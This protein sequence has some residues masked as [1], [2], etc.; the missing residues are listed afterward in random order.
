MPRQRNAGHFS[1][2]NR[3]R[4]CCHYAEG[5]RE[6]HALTSRTRPGQIVLAAEFLHASGMVHRNVKPENVLVNVNGYVRLANFGAAKQLGRGGRAYTLCGTPDYMAPEVVTYKGYGL[7]VDHW[8]LGVVL[9]EMV[10]GRQPFGAADV[11]AVFENAVRGRYRAPASFSP[12]LRS[13]I[14]GLVQVSAMTGKGSCKIQSR[15][16]VPTVVFHLDL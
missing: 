4:H 14:H 1:S 9:F 12:Q 3:H 7:A 6:S 11:G 16:G 8:S 13:L 5:P 15:D 10:A 2:S